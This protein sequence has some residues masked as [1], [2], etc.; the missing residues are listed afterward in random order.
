MK[1]TDVVDFH[2]NVR[3]IAAEP[4]ARLRRKDLLGWAVAPA[5]I[6]RRS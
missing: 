1:L 4:L 3:A 6:K 2:Y 5:R